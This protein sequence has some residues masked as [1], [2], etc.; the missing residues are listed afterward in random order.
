MENLSVIYLFASVIGLL[1]TFFLIKA[2]VIAGTEKVVNELQVN[3][4]LMRRS[5]NIE[6]K[7]TEGLNYQ[8]QLGS[9]TDEDYHRLNDKF[10]K[11]EKRRLKEQR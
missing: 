3:N 9:F 10:K 4:S 2:A 7:D 5:L 11:E 6:P 8:Y 1:I